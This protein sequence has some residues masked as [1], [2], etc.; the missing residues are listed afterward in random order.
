[1]F[2]I[3]RIIYSKNENVLALFNILGPII[4]NGVNF[5]TVPIFTRLL[6]TDNYGVVSLYTTW[7]QV[8][9][10]IMG[11]QTGGTIAVSRAHLKEEEQNEYYSSIIALSC[12]SSVV[13]T[14]LTALFIGPISKFMKFSPILV[15]IMLFQSFGTYMINFASL[16][17]TYHKEA[18]SNFSISTSVA[19]VS[20]VLSLILVSCINSFEDRYW[21]RIIGYAVPTGIA[22]IGI[23]TFFLL[24]GKT[25]FNS[26]YWKFCLPL[27]LPLVFH[28]LSHIVLGQSDRIMLQQQLQSTGA[29]GIYSFIFTLT[30]IL[31][32][33]WSALNNTWVPFYYDYLSQKDT[34]TIMRRSN[35]YIFLF[36]ALCIGFV[37]VAPEFTMLFASKDFWPGM[38]LIPIMVIS[39]YMVFLYSFPVN[40]EFYHKKTSVIAAGTCGAAILNILFNFLLIPI[41]G[42]MGAALATMASYVLLFCFHQVLAHYIGQGTYHYQTV[43]FLPGLAVLTLTAI[44]FY[45]ASDFWYIRWILALITGVLLIRRIVRQK[46][47]F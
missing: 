44:I 21:G 27:C 2:K 40:F 46:S 26:R 15:F 39:V 30:H 18:F 22:G 20:V 1:M 8:F 13:I 14:V 19:V 31:T 7:V 3:R 29:V 41:W 28:G 10:I 32:I 37:L 24:R 38:D 6:G 33:I 25:F 4:L 12:L 17:F 9:S 23:L 42:I 43:K 5:F 16:K 47:I 45:I 35:N 11:V 34:K 36:T